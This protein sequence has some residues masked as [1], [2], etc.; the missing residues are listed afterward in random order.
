MA[1]FIGR[2]GTDAIFKALQR[3]CIVITAYNTKITAAIAIAE[4]AGL[5]TAA[6]ASLAVSFIEGARTT[7]D[8][9]KIVASNSGFPPS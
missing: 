9:F 7:C 6:Q 1:T 2:S 5:I 4:G 3:I 8:I